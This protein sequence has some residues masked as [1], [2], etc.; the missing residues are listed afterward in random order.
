MKL[1]LNESRIIWPGRLT[2][3]PEGFMIPT[4][5]KVL[6]IEEK[7]FVYV[8]P[9][10]KDDGNSCEVNEIMC[11]LYNTSSKGMTFFRKNVYMYKE[12]NNLF[13]F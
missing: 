8:R 12:F 1:R 9:L 4:H 6:T 3:K 10:K 2:M 7:P 5:L 13:K 11:P